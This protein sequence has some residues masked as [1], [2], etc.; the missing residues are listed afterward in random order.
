M[1]K[2]PDSK[3]LQTILDTIH[4]EQRTLTEL[5]AEKPKLE[6]Q[7]ET[8]VST[9]D[10]DDENIIAQ[11]T[12]LRTRLE[13]HPHRIKR[14]E[15]K[16]SSMAHEFLGQIEAF[17]DGIC[18]SAAD[19]KEALAL[20]I[21]AFLKPYAPN[22]LVHGETINRAKDTAYK[23][24]VMSCFP[25]QRNEIPVALMSNRGEPERALPSMVNRASDLVSYA[26]EV[27][28]RG[29]FIPK[30]YGKC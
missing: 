28:A 18:R 29:S 19:E 30:N 3:P 8:L 7:V 17:E 2:L 20:T 21:E 25:A 14:Q 10:C 13:M 6:A 23:L 22:S 5:V 11:I 26:K 15:Q 16:L 9:G 1:T 12:Q 24:P 4:R 27:A